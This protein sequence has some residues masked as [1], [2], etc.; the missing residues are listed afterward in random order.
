MNTIPLEITIKSARILKRVNFF[1]R[2]RIYIVVSLIGSNSF[3]KQR[4]NVDL[5]NG[6]EPCWWFKMKFHVEESKI[7][8]NACMLVLQVRC[9]KPLGDKDIGYLYVPVRELFEGV[10]GPTRCKDV[11]YTVTTSSGKPKGILYLSYEFGE[12]IMVK[13]VDKEI[14]RVVPAASAPPLEGFWDGTTSSE[15]SAPPYDEEN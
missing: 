2:R 15:A 10:R 6:S 9:S 1:D 14:I 8:A 11:A 3:S 13:G 5:R 4:T 12:E 7:H